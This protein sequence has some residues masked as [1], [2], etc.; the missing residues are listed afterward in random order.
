M[1]ITKQRIST[2]LR[3]VFVGA[4]SILVLAIFA[5]G[6]AEANQMKQE[7]TI[8]AQEVSLI[9]GFASILEGPHVA[10]FNPAN[11]TLNS[12]TYTIFGT[13]RWSSNA[14]KS[15][16]LL[17][18]AQLKIV[19]SNATVP[20]EYRTYVE[21]GKITYSSSVT[22]DDSTTLAAFTGTGDAV[23][24]L[25]VYTKDS[26]DL[27]LIGPDETTIT[28]EVVYDYTPA[29]QTSAVPGPDAPR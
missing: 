9:P 18:T 28:G 25:L 29:I 11:G 20:L 26:G 21:P 16:Q 24:A 7:F 3:K 4:V 23:P 6:T 13:A 17:V 19:P 15:A 1:Q 27:F 22:N 8:P 14:G 10:Q 5:A 2:K 12:V